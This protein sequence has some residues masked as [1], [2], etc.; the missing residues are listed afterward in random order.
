MN[1]LKKM[2]KKAIIKRILKKAEKPKKR[3]KIV[4]TKTRQSQEEKLEETREEIESN[5]INT[6]E[7]E[8]LFHG[9]I[10]MSRLDSLNKKLTSK[11]TK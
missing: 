6:P 1:E 7:R 4:E 5:K 9:A 10:F 3:E 8:S 2:I 11:W